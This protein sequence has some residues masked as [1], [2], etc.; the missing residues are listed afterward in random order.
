MILCVYRTTI[1]FI[2]VV[3]IG[4]DS[5]KYLDKL[6]RIAHW[7]LSREEATDIINDYREM[8]EEKLSSKEKISYEN[9][10][11]V[12]KCFRN[13]KQYFSWLLVFIVMITC[14]LSI[15]FSLFVKEYYGV[16]VVGLYIL[17]QALSTFYFPMVDKTKVSQ[18]YPKKFLFLFGL[19]VFLLLIILGISLEIYDTFH[20]NLSL[21]ENI[22]RADNIGKI[23]TFMIQIFTTI[24]SAISIFSLYEAKITDRRWR[25]LYSFGIT[26]IALCVFI[27]SNLY[28][29]DLSS[30]Q[31]IRYQVIVF[32]VTGC[33]VTGVCLH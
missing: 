23:I 28:N 9:P 12:I 4:G 2:V 14:L 6:S 32:W 8:L 22:V 27:F 20:I 16:L 13:N 5:M 31:S 1:F 25:A 19:E 30:M 17:G 33:V 26:V 7:Q 24:L 29:T 21:F 15:G 3:N 18:P 10:Y 11:Q